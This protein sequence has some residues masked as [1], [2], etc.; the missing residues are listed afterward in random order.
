M[1]KAISVISIV[2]AL[3]CIYFQSLNFLFGNMNRSINETRNFVFE[4]FA[5]ISTIL[6]LI[7]FTIKQVKKVSL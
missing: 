5:Q 7:W 4:D 6:I 2:V 1:K 3:V